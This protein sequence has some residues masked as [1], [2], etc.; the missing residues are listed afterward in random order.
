MLPRDP[1][2][3]AAIFLLPLALMLWVQWDI[4]EPSPTM[5]EK[6][7]LTRG[8]AVWMEGD[9]RFSYSHPPLA[10]AMA[11][12]PGYL[13]GY[14]PNL[15]VGSAWDEAR[16]GKMASKI[17]YSKANYPEF[18]AALVKGRRVMATLLPLLFV[19]LWWRL[20][21]WLSFAEAGALALVTTLNPVLWTNARVV[22]TDF[23]FAAFATVF[24]FELIALATGKQRRAWVVGLAMGCML[25]SKHSGAII[26]ASALP[27]F[28]VAWFL[29]GKGWR[30]C[31]VALAWIG[32]VALIVVNTVFLWQHT[33]LTV[34]TMLHMPEPKYKYSKTFE[35]TMLE[36]SKVA[37]LPGWLPLPFPYTYVFGIA[38]VAQHGAK[39]HDS[40][41]MGEISRTGWVSYFPVVVAIKMSLGPLI[42]TLGGLGALGLA[43]RRPGK[44]WS[45]DRSAVIVCW[46]LLLVTAAYL[47]VAMNSKLNIGSRH[48]LPIFLWLPLLGALSL[49]FVAEHLELRGKRIAHWVIVGAAAL[50]VTE[51]T[52]AQRDPTAYFNPFIGSQRGHSISILGE[53]GQDAPLIIADLKRRGIT[54]IQSYWTR[55]GTIADL[56]Q[57]GIQVQSRSC[58]TPPEPGYVIFERSWSNRRPKCFRWTEEATRVTVLR[59]RIEIWQVPEGVQWKTPKKASSKKSSTKKK[60]STKKGAKKAGTKKPSAATTSPTRTS[61]TKAAPPGPAS[62]GV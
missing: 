3:L 45:T 20:R 30:Q 18:R 35:G 54:N 28:V 15:R 43:L 55:P 22:M 16:V 41:F 46:F 29:T 23:P 47:G 40:W 38:G 36:G 48:A 39:G 58:K 5:D 13:S 52:F 44:L 11:A 57:A 59:H 9:T 27:L 32:I 51:A 7:H 10:N 62:E 1:K 53:G 19:Y 17:A 6:N 60:P 56:R 26:A 61:P 50:G 4:A 31:V 37:K 33:F 42:A 2:R 14:R 49:H 25:S 12:L 24:V 8:M 34:D 21:S